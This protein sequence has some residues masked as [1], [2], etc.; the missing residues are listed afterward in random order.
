MCVCAYKNNWQCSFTHKQF[1]IKRSFFA[2][3]FPCGHHRCG[4]SSPRKSGRGLSEALSLMLPSTHTWDGFAGFIRLARGCY[5]MLHIADTGLGTWL[6]GGGGGGCIKWVSDSE[7]HS[8]KGCLHTKGEFLFW[9]PRCLPPGTGII[10]S[11]SCSCVGELGVVYKPGLHCKAPARPETRCW[12]S[13][14]KSP[15]ARPALHLEEQT[16]PRPCHKEAALCGLWGPPAVKAAGLSRPLPVGLGHAPCQA[17]AGPK[18]AALGPPKHLHH[19][20]QRGPLPRALSGVVGREI[21][22]AGSPSTP[23][24]LALSVSVGGNERGS[25]RPG[26]EIIFRLGKECHTLGWNKRL[27]AT[28]EHQLF[29][30][31]LLFLSCLFKSWVFWE[32]QRGRPSIRKTDITTK[33]FLFCSCLMCSYH[34]EVEE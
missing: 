18:G 27:L 17:Q 32:T 11:N 30:N 22:E 4:V 8:L 23:P 26:R 25:H 20:R 16:A 9:K 6:G 5:L 12:V 31:H 29:Q 34:G 15:G 2:S 28:A 3:C 7:W 19:K 1:L 33:K 13:T 10:S 21:P 14:C 24:L